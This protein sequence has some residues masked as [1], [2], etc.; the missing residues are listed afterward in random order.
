MHGRFLATL[1][2]T[3][4]KYVQGGMGEVRGGWVGMMWLGSGRAPGIK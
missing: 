1:P 2:H 3:N 4:E